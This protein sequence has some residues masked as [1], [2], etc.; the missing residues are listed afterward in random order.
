MAK[1]DAQKS[2]ESEV[3]PAAEAPVD[4][5]V[6][7]GTAIVA[8]LERIEQ[9]LA[10]TAGPLAGQEDLEPSRLTTVWTHPSGHILSD[11]QY[12]RT[13]WD[14]TGRYAEVRARVLAA[15]GERTDIAWYR[16]DDKGRR[17]AA[18]RE[19]FQAGRFAE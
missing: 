1:D 13:I 11:D 18:G 8:L 17:K 4:P 6:S 10:A 3:T 12:G 2:F 5:I 9:R 7:I 16:T 14:L 19:Y 15:A